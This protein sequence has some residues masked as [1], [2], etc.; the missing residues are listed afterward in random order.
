MTPKHIT[1]QEL[2]HFCQNK[3]TDRLLIQSTTVTLETEHFQ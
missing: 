1:F 2:N 3:R